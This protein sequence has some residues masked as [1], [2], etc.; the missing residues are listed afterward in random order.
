MATLRR[1]DIIQYDVQYLLLT[2]AP[3]QNFICGEIMTFADLKE[4]GSGSQFCNIRRCT[5]DKLLD[6]RRSGCQSGRQVY[7]KRPYLRDARRR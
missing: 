2:C 7:A 4:A 5:A 1:L 3:H 6:V